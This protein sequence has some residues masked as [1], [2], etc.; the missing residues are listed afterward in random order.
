MKQ[1]YHF[2]NLHN[3][4]AV[5]LKVAPQVYLW[6]PKLPPHP[7]MSWDIPGHVGPGTLGPYTAPIAWTSQDVLP[8]PPSPF[9][10]TKSGPGGPVLVSKK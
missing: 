3:T 6:Q 2:T 4:R 10:A 7:R 1:N 9:L 5:M 8:P